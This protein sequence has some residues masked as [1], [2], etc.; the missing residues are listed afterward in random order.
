MIQRNFVY[1]FI[2]VLGFLIIFFG[3]KLQALHIIG[4]EVSYSCISQDT[5]KKTVTLQFIFTMYRDS[6]SSGANFDTFADFGIYRKSVDGSSW[7]YYKTVSNIQV[8]DINDISIVQTN[9]CVIIP[10]NVG[11]Q[12]GTYTFTV[13][14]P[15]IDQNYFISYQRCCRNNTILNLIAPGDTGAAFT[16]EVTPE[17]QRSCNSSPVFKDFPPVVICANHALTFDHSAI[18]VDGD[19]LVYKFCAPLTAGGK[20]GSDGGGGASLCT[21]VS[22]SPRNC[23]PPYDEVRFFTPNYSYD[24]PMGGNPQITINPSTGLITGVPNLLGQYVVGVCVE[25][26][27]NGKLIGY[28]KR[29]FQF[30]VTSCEDAVVADM[31]AT[32]KD[33]NSY[34][35]ISCGETEINFVNESTDKRFIK[36]YYWEFDISGEKKVFSTRDVNVKFPGLGIYN[37]VMILNKDIVGAED[38]RDTA[39]ITVK[40][41]PS[42]EANYSYHF[43]RCVAGPITFMDS[44]FSGAGP[45]QK[46]KWDFKQS[47][48]NQT[49]PLFEFEKPGSYPVTLFVEDVNNCKDTLTKIIDYF[50]AAKLIVV[51]PNTFIGCQPANI[52]FNNLSQPID[53]TYQ[54]E[55]HFGDGEMGDA[56]SPT[57]T[58]QDIGSYDV[59]LKITSPDGCSTEKLWRNLIKVVESPQAGFGFTPEKPN[60]V[61]NTVEFSDESLNAN[62]YFWKFD[63]L[64]ISLLQ[65]PQF[66]FRDTGDFQ[67][68]QVVLHTNGCADT[69][70][71]LIHV[72]PLVTLFMPNAFTPNNDGLNDVYAPVGNFFGINDYKLSIFNRWGERVFYSEDVEKGWDGY[73]ENSSV[74]A[75]SGVYAFVVTYIDGF[76]EKNAL[77]GQVTLLR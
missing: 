9:P 74:I 5:I 4:G 15:I 71:V 43:E 44:S 16:C 14:L 40:I 12:K 53:E 10:L 48:S 31:K 57:H 26:Y 33:G 1:R 55:W 3:Q 69:S 64:G 34:E 49:N 35:L 58:Y 32:L 30:N 77:K 75:P 37:A 42:I 62:S 2:M 41:F 27:R 76:G 36:Q 65:N 19:S 51:D 46:W 11:V 24:N 59:F 29:D 6:K 20:D 52:Y 23:P 45:I 18:D 60:S 38:C 50:P 47:T 63:S 66:T 7:I 54:L 28:L 68:T 73:R 17:A 39:T 72:S 56:I 8:K 21:G 61:Q 67:V 22:P 70:T 25:E 13:T